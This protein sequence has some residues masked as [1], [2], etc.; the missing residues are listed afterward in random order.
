VTMTLEQGKNLMRTGHLEQAEV[1]LQH[2]QQLADHF[3]TAAQGAAFKEGLQVVKRAKAALELHDVATWL[4]FYSVEDFLPQRGWFVLDAGCRFLWPQRQ[5]LVHPSPPLEDKSEKAIREDLLSMAVL[6][7]DLQARLAGPESA[8][9]HQAALAILDE[10][11]TLFGANVV[12][13]P[14]PSARLPRPCACPA[15]S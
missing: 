13:F 9:S 10:A 1:T 11:E 14:A 15:R 12:L 4:R 8:R 5:L 7:G 3:G 6:W 2:G